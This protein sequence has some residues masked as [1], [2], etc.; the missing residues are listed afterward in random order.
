MHQWIH[1]GSQVQGQTVFVIKKKT[2]KKSN[3][4]KIETEV[5]NKIKFNGFEIHC[6]GNQIIIEKLRKAQTCL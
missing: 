3:W 2:L 5:T 6:T 1:V 4:G